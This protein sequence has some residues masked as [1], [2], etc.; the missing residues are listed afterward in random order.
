M[1]TLNTILLQAQPDGGSSMS[2]IFMI[3]AM[4]VIFYFFMIRPQQ[5][6]RKQ[7]KQQREAMKK[8]D[9][10]LTQGGIHGT[11]REIGTN[12][13]TVEVAKGVNIK[14]STD[15]V[16]PIVDAPAKDAKGTKNAK[17]DK[18]DKDA[19]VEDDKIE[20]VEEK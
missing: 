16:Y 3:L 20:V 17:A 6:Q 15:C 4:V 7:L 13:I 5:R 10:V 2:G 12:T 19:K 8:G 9:K 1:T 11:I 18:A 14:V